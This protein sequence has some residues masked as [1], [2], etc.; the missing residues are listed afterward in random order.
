MAC[1]NKVCG[2]HGRRGAGNVALHG[3]SRVKWERRR[4]YR[5]ASCNKTFG[6]SSGTVYERLQHSRRKFDRVASLSVEGV[7]KADIAHIEGLCWNTVS[8][9]LELAAAYARKKRTLGDHLELLRFPYNFCRPHSALRF[10][11]VTRTPAMQAG[12]AARKLSFLDIFVPQPGLPCF[13][14]VRSCPPAYQGGG[15]IE[16]CAA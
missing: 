6:A 11:K 14:L 7:S 3:Y 8:R 5:C 12:L 10:G 1:P 9:W 2:S 16:N 13:V 15:G 4:R